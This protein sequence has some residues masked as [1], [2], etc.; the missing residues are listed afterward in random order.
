MA[1]ESRRMDSKSDS[2]EMIYPYVCFSVDNFDEAFG[3]IQ[4]RA[5]FSNNLYTYNQHKK[6]WDVVV[7]LKERMVIDHTLQSMLLHNVA[8][9]NVNVT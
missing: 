3:E 1:A 2:E 7:C 8:Q 9:P 4:V 5:N 6:K